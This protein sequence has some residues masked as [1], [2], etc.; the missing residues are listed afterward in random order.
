MLSHSTMSDSLRPCGLQPARHLC[1]WDFPSKNI[2]VGCHFLLQ[3]IF[4][5]QR[6]NPCLLCLLHWQ[7]DF[8]NHFTTFEI[9]A[10]EKKKKNRGYYNYDERNNISQG[11]ENIEKLEEN[12]GKDKNQFSAKGSFNPN[13]E[14]KVCS[15]ICKVV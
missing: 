4:P 14:E 10:K 3:G 8:F 13:L 6:S 9:L 15:K 7:A 1:P 5:T 2:G 12:K 11:K